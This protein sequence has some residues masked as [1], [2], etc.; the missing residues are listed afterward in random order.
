MRFE[1]KVFVASISKTEDHGLG[2][3]E[4]QGARR[5]RERDCWTG[6]KRKK[7]SRNWSSF[8]RPLWVGRD[9]ARGGQVDN[10]TFPLPWPATVRTWLM[11]P[12][13]TIYHDA[14]AFDPRW[15]QGSKRKGLHKGQQT[16]PSRPSFP[17]LEPALCMKSQTWNSY[18]AG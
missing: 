4:K 9:G 8:T 14:V 3:E 6:E 10:I 16:P 13:A 5:G 12:K 1:N 17:S 2:E 7:K 11:L 15:G 18:C